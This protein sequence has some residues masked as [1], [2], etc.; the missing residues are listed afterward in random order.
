MCG[1]NGSSIARHPCEASR[2]DRKESGSVRRQTAPSQIYGVNPRSDAIVVASHLG[3][4]L[5]AKRDDAG[6]KSLRLGFGFLEISS[7]FQPFFDH[8]LHGLIPL[9]AEGPA[10]RLCFASKLRDN[11]RC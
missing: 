10:E 9:L 11:A 2:N 6:R 1:T 8:C 3:V 7:L 4:V 5:L